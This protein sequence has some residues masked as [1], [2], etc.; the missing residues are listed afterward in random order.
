[1]PVVVDTS[2]AACWCFPDEAS[3]A[4]D[5]AL[6][7]LS[8]TE[9]LVPRLFWFELRNVL[10]VGERRNRITFRQIQ[11][12]LAEIDGLPAI[13]DDDCVE[14]LLM[15]LAR[16]HGLTAYDAAYLELAVRYGAALAT[17]DKH[18]ARAAEAEA[19][20]LITGS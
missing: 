14:E 19:V 4:A 15:T 6:D 1:M 2:V 3:T 11:E 7:T 12:G 8:D 17:L 5:D 13:V 10:L 9:L 18:L 16:R 20:T